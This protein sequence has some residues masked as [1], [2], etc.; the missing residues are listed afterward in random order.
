MSNLRTM[1]CLVIYLLSAGISIFAQQDIR[2]SE[3][4][5][6]LMSILVV[7]DSNSPV[8]ITGPF[9]IFGSSHGS[10][11]LNYMLKNISNSGIESIS[12]HETDWFNSRG[13]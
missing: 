7:T 6:E 3:V 2:R 5:P 10:L 12:V 1:F 4:P 13:Y 11:E 8:R 9:K